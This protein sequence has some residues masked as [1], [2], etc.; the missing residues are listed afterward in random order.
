M[1]LRRQKTLGNLFKKINASLLSHTNKSFLLYFSSKNNNNNKGYR[2][3]KKQPHK[4]HIRSPFKNPKSK[5]KLSSSKNNNNEKKKTTTDNTD[6]DNTVNKNLFIICGSIVLVGW[7]SVILA[8]GSGSEAAVILRTWTQTTEL[9]FND[10]YTIVNDGLLVFLNASYKNRLICEKL[11]KNKLILKKLIDIIN[12]ADS[13]EEKKEQLITIEMKNMASELLYAISLNNTTH[14]S[15]IK[16][17]IHYY[18]ID[19][20]NNKSEFLYIKKNCAFV[21]SNLIHNN[22]KNAMIILKSGVLNSLHLILSNK[23]LFR[24]KI[25]DSMYKL[26]EIIN[27]NNKNTSSDS[28]NL[29]EKKNL[30]LDNNDLLIINYYQKK[31]QKK[32]SKNN[33]F[34]SHQKEKFKNK[35]I[36][37]GTILY[38]HTLLGGALWGI[39]VSLFRRI[40]NKRQIWQYIYRT[41]LVTGFVPAY[42]IGGIVTQYNYQLKEKN[43]YNGIMMLNFITGMLILIPSIYIMP[44]LD[45]YCPLWLGGHIVGFSTFFL[46]CYYEDNDLFKSDINLKKEEELLNKRNKRKELLYKKKFFQID[47]NNDDTAQ[48]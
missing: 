43:T 48:K 8:K 7:I 14:D 11:S 30:N 40:K 39:T 2:I 6:N 18:L 12:A 3:I 45:L 16:N 17:K 19:I 47:N 35:L 31:L 46:Q 42:F 34:F 5:P 33:F 29:L 41:A 26:I 44:I 15:L 23:L 20:I 21:L 37:N 4:V 13:K 22:E 24:H 25:Q 36:E 27:K 9:L 28:D 32:K 38:M 10:D 1:F